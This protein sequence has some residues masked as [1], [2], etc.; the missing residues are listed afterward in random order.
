M[1]FN[2]MKVIMLNLAQR[3]SVKGYMALIDD[4]DFEKV[5]KYNWYVNDRS[6]T[7]NTFY[8]EAHDND[9]RLRMHRFVTNC[10][11]GMMVDHINGNGLDNRKENLRICTAS[12]NLMNRAAVR[13]N[14]FGYKGVEKNGTTFSTRIKAKGVRY[15]LGN[16]RTPKEAAIAYNNAAIKYHGDFAKLNEIKF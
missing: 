10:P 15:Y 13:K 7:R 16:F 8:A 5:S 4:E 6:K 2:S 14:I 12:E 3:D 1:R 9:K 11:K